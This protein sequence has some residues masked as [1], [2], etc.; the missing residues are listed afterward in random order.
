M[1]GDDDDAGFKT[2]SQPLLNRHV[3]VSGGGGRSSTTYVC[4]LNCSFRKF[5]SQ[6]AQICLPLVQF[7][8]HILMPPLWEFLGGRGGFASYKGFWQR[9]CYLILLLLLNDGDDG[10]E[11]E[12]SGYV[13]AEDDAK[14]AALDEL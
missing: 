9:G 1:L 7:F 10:G 14:M 6:F 3:S 11:R 5:S 13:S 4:F 2:G 12:Q 8:A